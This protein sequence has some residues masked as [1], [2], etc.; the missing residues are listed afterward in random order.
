MFNDSQSFEFGR[1]A[2]VDYEVAHGLLWEEET[3]E[4]VSA[5]AYY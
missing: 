1:E 5:Y 2:W 4:L 3:P